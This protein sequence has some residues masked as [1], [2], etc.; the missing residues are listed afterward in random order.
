MTILVWLWIL[1]STIIYV[2]FIFFKNESSLVSVK[3]VFRDYFKLVKIRDIF[4][5]VIYPFILSLGI[6]FTFFYGMKFTESMINNF[7]LVLSIF[8]TMFFAILSVL[9]YKILEN[10]KIKNQI[11][12]Y[13]QL[14]NVLEETIN[15]SMF[16]IVSCLILLF[17]CLLSGFVCENSTVLLFLYQ[18]IITGGFMIVFLNIFILIKRLKVLFDIYI[19]LQ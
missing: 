2:V 3:N 10:E 16:E 6:N 11:N 9:P 5:F 8:I 7:N 15:L 1:L 12:S 17:A 13:P 14:K 4:L 19:K 18:S